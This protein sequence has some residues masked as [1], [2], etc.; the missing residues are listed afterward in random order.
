MSPCSGPDS[1]TAVEARIS[2]YDGRSGG[3]ST[4]LDFESLFRFTAECHVTTGPDI[5]TGVYGVI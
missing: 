3:R 2:L 5:V 4:R 1:N